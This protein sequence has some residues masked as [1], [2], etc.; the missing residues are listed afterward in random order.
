MTGCYVDLIV[1]GQSL[2]VSK[3]SLPKSFI[4]VSQMVQIPAAGVS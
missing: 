3:L 4:E 1:T 2:L